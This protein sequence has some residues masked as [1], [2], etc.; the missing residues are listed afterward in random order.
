[1]G[2]PTTFPH[3]QKLFEVRGRSV[4]TPG[5]GSSHIPPVRVRVDT[6]PPL[7]LKRKEDVPVLIPFYTV[8][9]GPPTST[10]TFFTRSLF[11]P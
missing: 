7:F 4:R 9:Q 6:H 8:D 1:M 5:V 10:L 11:V 3:T 2:G